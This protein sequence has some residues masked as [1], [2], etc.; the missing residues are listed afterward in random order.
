[1]ENTE[2]EQIIRQ[3]A[4]DNDVTGVMDLV[5]KCD[6]SYERVSR[7]WSGSVNAKLCDVAHVADVLGMKIKFVSSG[8][9]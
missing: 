8:E 6:I 2:L 1:M 5:S 7:V 9:D 4:L 3:A